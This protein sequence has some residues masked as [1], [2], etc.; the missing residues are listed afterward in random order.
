MEL[1]SSFHRLSVRLGRRDGSPAS[2]Q[3][4]LHQRV[5]DIAPPPG[6]LRH[7]KLHKRKQIRGVIDATSP[8]DH[9]NAATS[10]AKN[11]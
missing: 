6:R 8:Y 3:C 9:L 2:R 10:T 7:L 5:F 11:E 4:I 1:S